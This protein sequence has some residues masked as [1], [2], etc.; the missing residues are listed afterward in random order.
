MYDMNIRVRYSETDSEGRARIS[1]ILD[2]FQ[3]IATFH[4]M[5]L[6]ALEKGIISEDHVWYLL[7]WDVT[8]DLLWVVP[9]H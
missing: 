6:G 2:Y 8:I 3:D 9:V 5:S 7:S 4:S 1:H